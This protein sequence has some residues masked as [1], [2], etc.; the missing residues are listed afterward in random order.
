MTADSLR[1]RTVRGLGWNATELLGRRA[2][3]FVIGV[4]LARL[5]LPE[6]FGLIGVLTG[7][8]IV[9]QVFADSGL[10]PALIQ[11]LDADD[12]DC[13]TIFYANILFSLVI[14]GVLCAASPLIA[15]M[16]RHPATGAVDLRAV[17]DHRAGFLRFCSR[18]RCCRGRW[19]FA[20]GARPY[21]W[22]S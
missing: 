22:R 7:F 14:Y 21:C 10:T 20:A 18:V 2:V 11:K 5:L 19:I 16:F 17:V 8:L 4:V 9:A 3:G 12:T 15:A 13:C 1:L 6:E